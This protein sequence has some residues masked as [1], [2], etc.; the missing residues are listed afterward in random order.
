MLT[1]RKVSEVNAARAARWHGH[2]PNHDG[3]GGSDWS[4]AM[5]GEAGETCNV[6][7]KL[8][9]IELGIGAAEPY[10]RESLLA[11]LA[12]EI[13]DT[14]LYLDLLAQFYGLDLAQCVADTFNR[15]SVREGFPERIPPPPRR[16][17]H[18]VTQP[19]SRADYIRSR[20]SKLVADFVYYDR[21][22]DE[23]LP[24]GAIQEA[25]AAN[26]IT[27]SEMAEH[28]EDEL[29]RALGIRR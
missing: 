27:W 18:A 17:E 7:K 8:R 22:E 21:K 3:F 2:F 28:F 19:P 20:I 26:E 9:R 16:S 12:K 5:A 1:I 14:Y 29:G 4:N 11:E 25:I 15:V 24:S 13:G 23:R 10:T 6:V